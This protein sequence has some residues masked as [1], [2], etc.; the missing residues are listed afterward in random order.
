MNATMTTTPQQTTS[1]FLDLPPELRST[2]YTHLIVEDEPIDI[3]RQL[4]HKPEHGSAVPSPSSTSYTTS[5]LPATYFLGYEYAVRPEIPP[6]A[7]V[8]KLIRDEVLPL[9]FFANKCTIHVANGYLGSSPLPWTSVD[10]WRRHTPSSRRYGRDP[11]PPCSAQP[12]G[13][14]LQR[15]FGNESNAT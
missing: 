12:I 11:Q 15:A 9:Y 6:I 4:V 2:I 14:G 10:E 5:T 3:Y 7:S 13:M 8:S 1:Y